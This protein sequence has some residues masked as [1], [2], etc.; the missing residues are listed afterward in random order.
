MIIIVYHKLQ[1]PHK[2]YSVRNDLTI[3]TII[4]LHTNQALEL[5]VYQVA[6]VFVSN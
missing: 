5:R 6:R 2:Q 1:R 4:K 3:T